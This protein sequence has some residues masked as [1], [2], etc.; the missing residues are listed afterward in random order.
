MGKNEIA[1]SGEVPW[2]SWVMVR[3]GADGRITAACG[4][5]QPFLSSMF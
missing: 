2:V 1:D 3:H 4:M 5:A